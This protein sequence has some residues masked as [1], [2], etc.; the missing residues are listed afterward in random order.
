MDIIVINKLWYYRS[1]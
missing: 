1:K